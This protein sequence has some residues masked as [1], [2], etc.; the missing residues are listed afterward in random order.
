MPTRVVGEKLISMYI[1]IVEK[2]HQFLDL[3]GFQQQLL[4]FWDHPME[5]EDKLARLA[6]CHFLPRPRSSSHRR[7]WLD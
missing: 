6:F 7:L 3:P 5:A 4:H 1:D 2:T